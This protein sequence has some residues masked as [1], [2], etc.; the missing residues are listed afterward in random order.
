MLNI[1]CGTLKP[2]MVNLNF[3]DIRNME[4]FKGKYERTSAEKYD[5]F[6]KVLQQFYLLTVEF[7]GY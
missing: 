6:L 3:S 5:E 1:L 7:R 4:S 2:K